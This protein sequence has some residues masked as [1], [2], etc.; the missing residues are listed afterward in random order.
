LPPV[1]LAY[2]PEALPERLEACGIACM[3]TAF[4]PAGLLGQLYGGV[5]GPLSAAVLPLAVVYAVGAVL[6][7]LLP[8]K[9]GKDNRGLRDLLGVYR[10]LPGPLSNGALVRAY[11]GTLALLFSFVAFYTALEL[12][13][14]EAIRAAG[15]DLTTVRAIAVPAM[16]LALARPRRTRL[17]R[18]AVPAG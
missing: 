18:A 9:R 1:A 13:A 7:A 2:L 10:G 4:L 15:L 8:E 6:V 11:A 3:S 16:V 5:L 14:S 12:F 17:R